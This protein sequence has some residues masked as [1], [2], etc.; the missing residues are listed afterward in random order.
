MKTWIR[1]AG[2]VGVVALV[3]ATSLS[4]CRKAPPALVVHFKAVATG[5]EPPRG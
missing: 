2:A 4:G 3:S 5:G 1:W